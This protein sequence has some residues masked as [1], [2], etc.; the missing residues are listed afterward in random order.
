MRLG[1]LL[2]GLGSRHGGGGRRR[3]RGARA[4]RST[5]ARVGPGDALRRARRAARPT[6]ARHVADAVARGARGGR[7]GRRRSTRR[8]SPRGARARSRAALLGARGGAPGRRPERRAHAGRRHRHQRQDHHHVSARV[9]LARRGASP[10]RRS[11]RSRTASPAPSRPA[12]FT[13]PERPDAPALLAEM[14]RGGHDARGDGG[15]VAR[16][17]AASASTRLRF[18]A[19][20]L[21]QPDPRPPRLPRRHGD[22]LR[23]QGA[24]LPRAAC[25]AGQ[26]GRG[27]GGQRRRPGGRAAGRRA[28]AGA[29]CASAARPD[30]TVRLLDVETHA[31][32]HARRAGRSAA[33]SA[34]HEPA[35][36]RAA[37]REPALAAAAARGR[38]GRPPAAIAGG[39]RAPRRRRR[40]ASSASP[41]P[42]SPCSS[43]T[44]TR[45][46]RSSALLAR[47]GRSPPGA[48]RHGLR[49]RRRSRPRQAPADGRGRRRGERSWS[50]SR[51]TTRAPRTRSASSPT[52]RPACARRGM[53]SLAAPAPGARGYRRRARPPRGDRARGRRSRGRATS[54][55]SPARATRTTRSSAPRSGTSTT[56]RRCG[57][58]WSAGM[59]GR[60]S[61][62]ASATRLRARRRCSRRPAASSSRLGDRDALHRASPPTRRALAAGE[63]F[64]AIRGPHARR[65]RV[66][67]PTAG[68]ARRGRGAGRARTRVDR[69]SPCG[70]IVVRDTLAALGDLAAFHR[71]RRARA[72]ARDHGQQRQDDHQGDVA[73]ILDARRSVPRA[74]CTR[75]ARRTISSACRSRCS[76]SRRRSASPSSSSGMNDPGEIWRLAEIAE[77]DVGVIT[78]VAPAHLEDL[79]SLHGVGRGEGGAVPA[80]AS[81]GDRGRERRRPAGRAR[82]PPPSRAARGPL[83]RRDGDVRAEDVADR[84][85]DGTR[86]SRC[87]WRADAI[88]GAARRARDG[89][90]SPTRSR[91]P[92]AAHALGVVARRRAARRSRPSSRPACACRWRGSRTAST[93]LNDAYNANP[94][95]MAAALQHARGERGRAARSPCSARCASWA[96]RPSA[97]H[98]ELGAS[99]R[100][101]AA[102]TRSCCSAPHADDGAR[103]RRRRRACRPTRIVRG[104]RPRGRAARRLRGVLPRRRPRCCSRARAARAWSA[105]SRTSDARTARVMLY[106]LL[107]PLHAAYAP[108]NVFQYITFRTLLAGLTALTLSLAARARAHPPARGAADRPVDPR[109]RPGAHAVEGRH[110]DD[111]RRRSSSSRSLLSTLL[112][113]D[114]SDRYVWIALAV[115]LGARADRLRRRLRQ[116][117]PAQ[118]ARASPAARGSPAELA[119]AARRGADLR[120]VSEHG[121]HVT[122]PFLKDFRPDLGLLVRPVR[123]ARDRRRGQ[124]REPDRR[125]RRPRDRPGDDRRR[126]L[127]R[128][129]LRRRQRALRRV[130]PD[131]VRAPGRASWRSS[132][133][134]SRRRASASSGSTPIRRRC[135][136]ATSARSRSA[137]RSASSR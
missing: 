44:R 106:L 20:R 63:L 53:P 34:L 25:R 71:R 47:C 17:R 12:P 11:A 116:G 90:T 80:A 82:R 67:S 126:H 91:P 97:A 77:P 119:I 31:R 130:P 128:L 60:A 132:A 15:V 10:G 46:T 78:S 24:A 121:G 6:A 5:R 65:P 27:R 28:R 42:A 93:V 133:A 9:D 40:V 4:S 111:G 64:V 95:S 58:R 127:R 30:A 2:D 96:P 79:G 7:R 99:R 109:G 134:R 56:A 19:A 81:V 16:A 120:L 107:Y 38:S 84:G 113:A 41:G 124:R 136:W 35:G 86:S 61:D 102:S 104:A 131:P 122:M 48:L 74:C 66:S 72:R 125:A 26:A 54:S 101:G 36:R 51:R 105:C 3:R 100:R 14:R 89:T 50:C 13:T 39:T 59:S 18:D 23:R 117:A 62:C 123:R 49:L 75:A 29:A 43:T 85:L 92:R 94:A 32:R 110:A 98:R 52:S 8:T 88:A 22:V 55:W 114:L 115:T 76:G 137:R 112:L 135:S 73:A 103:R 118:L 1:A 37:R 69:R 83:R 57:A 70:V 87:A 68:A 108:L 21:H 129:R 33:A 45:P